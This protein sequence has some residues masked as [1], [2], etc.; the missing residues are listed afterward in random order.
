M[1]VFAW[2]IIHQHL[3][4]AFNWSLP[5]ADYKAGFGSTDADFWLGLEKTHLLTSSRPYRLRVEMQQK[6]MELWFS[7]EYW[8]FKIGDENWS[9]KIGD[10]YWSRSVSVTGRYRSVRSTGRSRSVPSTGHS[11]SVT[12]STTNTDWKCLDTVETP[13][14]RCSM[15]ATI[16]LTVSSI[17]VPAC[18]TTGWNLR[19]STRTM[20][21]MTTIVETAP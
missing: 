5:W 15:K 4:F 13:A 16:L 7:A 3:G 1:S 17:T 19:H 20:T 9:L 2:I 12:S 21:T 10:Q 14:T 11:R 18:V 8:S 6:D